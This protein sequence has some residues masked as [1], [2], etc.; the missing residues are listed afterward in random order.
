MLNSN[1]REELLALLKKY[2]KNE[3]LIRHS[4]AS[5]AVM[6]ALSKR[7]NGNENKWAIAGLLHD[8]DV[9]ITQGDIQTHTHKAVEILRENNI[10]EEIIE[11]IKMHNPMAWNNEISNN[12]FHIAL[13]SGE[14]ITGLIIATAYVYPDKK[15]SSVKV[16]SVLKRFKDKRFAQGADRNTILE[17]EKLGIPL[18]LFAEIS[19]NAM[20]E[21]S[22]ELGL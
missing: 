21:V 13:R 11:A 22:S 3:N 12:P 7:L 14:T 1:N 8:I 19:L 5:E 15:I 17:C 4:I 20:K 6:K 9:E 2:V 10:D 16:E 18:N